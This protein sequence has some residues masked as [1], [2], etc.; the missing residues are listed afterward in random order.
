MTKKGSKDNFRLIQITNL[1][2]AIKELQNLDN[3]LIKDF[4]TSKK[5]DLNQ[6]KGVLLLVF[7]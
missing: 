6:F 7:F 5:S 2:K 1:I 4:R 3:T